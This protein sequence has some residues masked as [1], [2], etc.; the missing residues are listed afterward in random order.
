MTSLDQ[1]QTKSN[2]L[3]SQN[4]LHVL[5]VNNSLVQSI[6][7]SSFT[8]T[9]L[10]RWCYLGDVGYWIMLT[11]NQNLTTVK[12]HSKLIFKFGFILVYPLF[13][14]PINPFPVSHENRPHYI[15]IAC[16]LWFTLSFSW[17]KLDFPVEKPA[18]VNSHESAQKTD[19]V[20]SLAVFI[21][22]IINLIILK[23]TAK[24]TKSVLSTE[25]FFVSVWS[26]LDYL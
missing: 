16:K 22:I 13:I 11:N 19:Y 5:T 25:L 4:L 23:W 17:L 21:Q 10:F 12:T 9:V 24:K 3:P 1:L 8:T 2:H 14:Y 26:W 15:K 20:Q 18:L 7:F 6:T